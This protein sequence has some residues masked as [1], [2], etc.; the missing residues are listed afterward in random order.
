MQ[1]IPSS[2]FNYFKLKITVFAELSGYLAF[3]P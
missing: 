2:A 1:D 3:I